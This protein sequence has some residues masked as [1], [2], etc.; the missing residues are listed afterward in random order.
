MILFSILTNWLCQQRLKTVVIQRV[1]FFMPAEGAIIQKV[2][3]LKVKK[4]N[5]KKKL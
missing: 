1:K 3:V 4:K 2:E 5:L